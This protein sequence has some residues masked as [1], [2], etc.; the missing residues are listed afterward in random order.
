MQ[1]LTCLT[2]TCTLR[3]MCSSQPPANL[4]TQNSTWYAWV[5]E[6]WTSSLLSSW[7]KWNLHIVSETVACLV[8][9]FMQAFSFTFHIACAIHVTC[10]YNTC[11]M[12][13]RY[14][15]HA[16]YNTCDIHVWY[17]WHVCMILVTCM[18]DTCD[19]HVRYLWH[20]CAILV[21]CMCLIII[22]QLCRMHVTYICNA[23][24]KHVMIACA[25][26][27]IVWFRLNHM[28]CMWLIGSEIHPEHFLPIRVLPPSFLMQLQNC[29][30]KFAKFQVRISLAISVASH[31]QR[32]GFYL[33]TWS[34]T[35]AI[36]ENIRYYEC[37]RASEKQFI[38]E[39]TNWM[40]Y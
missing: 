38:T 31:A 20:A 9:I 4:A 3:S 35:D 27:W 29:A 17:L 24:D 34:Q 16:L 2:C 1:M 13:V 19:M 6:E 39:V 30:A 8:G 37:M 22:T 14:M 36:S 25:A 18:C 26:Y 7:R 15:W 10:M 12:H 23:Y 33:Y 5:I 11:D 40:C 28:V 32:C 21:T